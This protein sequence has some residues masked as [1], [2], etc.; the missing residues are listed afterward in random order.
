M[1]EHR[2]RAVCQTRLSTITFYPHSLEVAYI[3]CYLV[4]ICQL[5]PGSFLKRGNKIENSGKDCNVIPDG[6]RQLAT[7]ENQEVRKAA[8]GARAPPV[9]SKRV[10][11]QRQSEGG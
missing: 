5:N 4:S 3:Q 10:G 6:G 1:V 11:V 9:L 8:L 7:D 2:Y